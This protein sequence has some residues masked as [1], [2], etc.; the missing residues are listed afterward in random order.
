[1]GKLSHGT[2]KRLIQHQYSNSRNRISSRTQVSRVQQN[3]LSTW[4]LLAKI[5]VPGRITAL[6]FFSHK[7]TLH[8]LSTCFRGAADSYL[9]RIWE[10][11]C[12][13]VPASP[14]TSQATL[15]WW[16]THGIKIYIRED[17]LGIRLCDC[18]GMWQEKTS[19]DSLNSWGKAG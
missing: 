15:G 10:P 12:G 3:N 11:G 19:V 8:Q 18:L 17:T 14:S 16:F 4:A 9:Y 6:L 5:K 1:M 2:T 7:N 13:L